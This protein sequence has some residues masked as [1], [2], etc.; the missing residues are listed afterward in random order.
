MSQNHRKPLDLHEKN[1]L[2]PMDRYVGSYAY[3]NQRRFRKIA[4]VVD[5][6]PP[7]EEFADDVPTRN[8]RRIIPLAVNSPEP[9]PG[10]YRDPDLCSFPKMGEALLSKVVMV[11]VAGPVTLAPAFMREEA[12][13]HGDFSADRLGNAYDGRFWAFRHCPFE[14]CLLDEQVETL[15]QTEGMS[16]CG[17]MS[18]AVE[19]GRVALPNLKRISSTLAR[20]VDHG[21][22]AVFFTRCPWCAT[23]MFDLALARHKIHPGA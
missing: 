11:I 7:E 20:F 16:C 12:I 10:A 18:Q 23:D 4:A 5:A 6:A 22:P 17:K 3:V 19:H 14:G 8:F 9:K 15:P 13:L 1:E 2:V 21:R